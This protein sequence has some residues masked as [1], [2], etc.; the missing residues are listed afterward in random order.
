[1]PFI[2][3]AKCDKQAFLKAV[4]AIA[5]GWINRLIPGTYDEIWVCDTC[6]KGR[7]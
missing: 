6:R 5:Q 1:M 4:T 7:A 3:C 2:F